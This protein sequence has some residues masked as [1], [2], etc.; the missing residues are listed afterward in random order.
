MIR[1]INSQDKTKT[2]LVSKEV[3]KESLINSFADGII[4]HFNDADFF[5]TDI[6]NGYLK[7]V[8][9]AIDKAKFENLVNELVE[10]GYTSN[11]DELTLE[12]QIQF[13]Y[14]YKFVDNYDLYELIDKNKLADLMMENKCG[15]IFSIDDTDNSFYT[16]LADLDLTEV[17][18]E[19]TISD[20]RKLIKECEQ[21]WEINY[22]TKSND[23]YIFNPKLFANNNFKSFVNTC[24][25]FKT[26]KE[27]EQRVKD[28]LSGK[29]NLINSTYSANE[30]GELVK[31]NVT[32]YRIFI[33][34]LD[35]GNYAS[36]SDIIKNVFNNSDFELSKYGT[37]TYYKKDMD[38]NEAKETLIKIA[39]DTFDKLKK[40]SNIL[41]LS[42]KLSRK[43]FINI[44]FKLYNNVTKRNTCIRSIINDFY[45]GVGDVLILYRESEGTIETYVFN[46][47][48]LE[49]IK[50]NQF[51][52]P[53]VK[54]KYY[55]LRKQLNVGDS[56]KFK[57]GRTGIVEDY[58]DKYFYVKDNNANT[59]K[60][61]KD[62]IVSMVSENL[63]EKNFFKKDRKD[64][65]SIC[66]DLNLAIENILERGDKMTFLYNIIN[67]KLESLQK[68]YEHSPDNISKTKIDLVENIDME[69]IKKDYEEVEK[70]LS[71]IPASIWNKEKKEGSNPYPI[72]T[73]ADL[74]EE[75]PNYFN[76]GIRNAY[77]F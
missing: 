50:T 19:K 13:L 2:K 8:A 25:H 1:I 37:I 68:R 65:F 67:D 4:G 24:Y 63:D 47:I 45:N 43:K 15:W 71:R 52:R 61:I 28:I 12:E 62:D 5:F 54:E 9:E 17:T 16:D 40:N 7:Y 60:I 74:E 41:E 70:V 26:V 22:S 72:Y 51:I 18:P 32:P 64:A 49:S 46:A 31:N 73:E 38:F 55:A 21:G 48:P 30:N 23:Y 11:L 14:Q 33:D 59:V 3:Y 57:D 58:D 39:K 42:K 34:V 77:E 36:G 69:K 76:Y 20:E 44:S 35:K 6:E 10:E 29:I 27:A 75:D 66:F 56:V 53:E